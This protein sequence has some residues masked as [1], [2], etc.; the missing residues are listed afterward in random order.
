M[1]YKKLTNLTTKGQTWSIKVKVIRV[2]NSINNATDELISMDMILMDEHVIF[3]INFFS[4][5]YIILILLNYCIF[6]QNDTIHATIWKSLLNTY[7]PQI[8]EGSIYVFSNF[9]LEGFI[10][11]RPLSNEKKYFLHVIQRWTKWMSHQISSSS[12]I[13]SLLQKIHR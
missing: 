6:E 10:R 11:Y 8:N 13:L 9:K 12:I 2:W 1:T 3:F 4:F 7:R 5:V